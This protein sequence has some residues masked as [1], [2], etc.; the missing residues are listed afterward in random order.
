MQENIEEIYIFLKI[1]SKKW[2][3][4][5]DYESKIEQFSNNPEMFSA[6][7]RVSIIRD[8]FTSFYLYNGVIVYDYMIEKIY[9]EEEI[10]KNFPQVLL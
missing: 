5:N 9:S 10:R 7:I 1:K 6:P 3:L 8:T 2:F 4:E